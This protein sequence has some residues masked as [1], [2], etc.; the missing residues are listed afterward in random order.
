M[1]HR[2]HNVLVGA[3][4][5][6]SAAFFAFS[7]A[8][9][10]Q[11]TIQCIASH[12]PFFTKYEL[13][14]GDEAC[15]GLKG[16]DI[17]LATYLAPNAD[18]TLANYDDR[19]V[20]IQ[21]TTLG[22]IA[23]E[24]EGAGYDLGTDKPYAFGK[25][26]TAP[27]ANNIC[28]A[29]GANGTAALAAADMNITEFDTGEV[30]DMGNPIILPAMHLQQEWRNVKVYVTAG[31]P[32]TQVVGEMVFRDVLAGCEA[33]YKFVGIS[34]SVY[35]GKD[36]HTDDDNNPDTPSDNDDADPAKKDT[37]MVVPEPLFCDPKAHPDL[38]ISV[39]SGINPDFPVA[40]DPE[41]LHCILT[42]DPLPG[43]P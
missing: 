40:C 19:S 33:S 23:R 42:G 28:Y 1:K 3:M 35:C 37:P 11:P 20:A 36:V 13:V 38:G 30:D 26:T 14:S 10:S 29:G 39:G 6:A 27:D 22:Q 2:I 41:T 4:G 24:R 16:E 34:P 8:S 25:Y 17:G 15:L 32:G 9:C 21:S 12:F 18:K 31:V 5:L 43:R 7:G